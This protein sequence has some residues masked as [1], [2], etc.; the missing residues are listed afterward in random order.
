MRP[1]VPGAVISSP[2]GVQ[3]NLMLRREAYRGTHQLTP[4]MGPRSE[5][6]MVLCVHREDG[7]VPNMLLLGTRGQLGWYWSGSWTQGDARCD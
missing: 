2:S 1:I 4:V 6:F 3:F 5:L 7:P